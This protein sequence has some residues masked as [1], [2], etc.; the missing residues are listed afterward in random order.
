V[1]LGKYPEK[2]VLGLEKHVEFPRERERGVTGDTRS[3]ELDWG[4][5]E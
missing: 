5:K 4:R 2:G 3:A 1:E